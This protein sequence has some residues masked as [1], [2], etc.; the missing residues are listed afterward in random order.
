[1]Q[2]ANPC[3]HKQWHTH[4]NTCDLGLNTGG[5]GSLRTTRIPTGRL[6]GY[7]G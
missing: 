7:D 5:L 2:M 6:M 4:T 3:N 1:M